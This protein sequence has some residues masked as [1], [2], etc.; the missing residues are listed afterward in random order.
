MFT[1]DP[2][3]SPVLAAPGVTED[4]SGDAA[5]VALSTLG[6][7]TPGLWYL[8]PSE[9]GPY[10]T[11]G[12]P[13]VTTS[14]SFDAVTRAFDMTVTPSTGDLWSEANGITHGFT[15]VY[16]LAGHSATMTVKIKPTAPVGSTV[17]AVVYVDDVY[18]A[19]EL[20]GLED[21]GGDELAALPFRYKVGR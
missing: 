2:D 17:T 19:N 12:A 13:S 16:V 9:L 7:V 10:T 11:S 5:S 14:A 6:E 3:L 18:M 20:I 21:T 8:N 15:P 1:G 4:Q